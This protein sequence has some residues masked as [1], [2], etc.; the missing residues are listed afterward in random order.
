VEAR[1]DTISGAT[2]FRK[3]GA[4]LARDEHAEFSSLFFS[5]SVTQA[6]RVRIEILK[7][8]AKKLSSP[9]ENA[10]VQG[11][12]SRPVLQYHAKAGARSRAEGIGR[13]YNFVDA[14]AKF[15]GRLTI[16]DLGLSY[17][18]AGTTFDGAMS[19]YFIVLDDQ[20]VGSGRSSSLNRA[21]PGRRGGRVSALRRGGS[22]SFSVGVESAGQD[23][24][25][26]RAGEASDGPSK[27]HESTAISDIDETIPTSLETE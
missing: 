5:N 13:S 23:R 22:R 9:T 27:K 1:F 19:Q 20:Y 16:D 25:T 11:F 4:K 26:K 14:M 12:L 7:A 24:G 2:L 3:E 8:L 17:Q 15:G 10:Y 6:T 21:P 18:R